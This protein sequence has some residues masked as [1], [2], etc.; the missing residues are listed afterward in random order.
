MRLAAADEKWMKKRTG[1]PMTQPKPATKP[2]MRRMPMRID[3]S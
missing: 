2:A 1:K 3:R